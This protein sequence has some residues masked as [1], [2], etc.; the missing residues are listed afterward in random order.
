VHG[1]PVSST[2]IFPFAGATKERIPVLRHFTMDLPSVATES[3]NGA[4]RHL[5]SVQEIERS[6]RGARSISGEFLRRTKLAAV[7]AWLPAMMLLAPGA[8]YGELN[9]EQKAPPASPSGRSRFAMTWDGA[10]GQVV[11]FGGDDGSSILGDTWVWD[12]STWTQKFPA[13]SPPALRETSMAYDA[14]RGQV[15]LFGGWDGRQLRSD[16]WIWDGST[17]TQTSPATSPPARSYCGLAGDA[18]RGQVVLFGGRNGSLTS[19]GDTWVWDGGT[20]TQESPA[21]SPPVRYSLGMAYDAARS[22]VVLFGGYGGDYLADTWVWDGSTWTQESPAM[23]PAARYALELTW[24][25]PK[26]QVVLFSGSNRFGSPADTWVW[27]GS[28]WAQQSP[29]VNPPGRTKF[30]M[31]YDELRQQVVIFGGL[32]DSSTLSDTWV[33]YDVPTVPVTITSALASA[34]FSVSGSNCQAG[35]GY[36]V[37]QTFQWLPGSFC[38]VTFTS[39]VSAGAG[40]QGIFTGWADGETSNPRTI[41][42]PSSPTTYTANYKTQYQLSILVSPPGAGTVAGQGYYDANTPASVV[43]TAGSGYLFA[44]WTPVLSPNTASSSVSMTGPQTLTAGFALLTSVTVPAVSGQYSD[45]VTLSATVGPPGA[46]FSGLLQFQVDGVNAGAPISVSGSGAYSTSYLITG[47]AGSHTITVTLAP[48]TPMALGSMGSNTLT[49]TREDATITPASGNPTTVKVSSPGGTANSITLTGQLREVSDG[50]PGDLSK[51]VVTVS[52]LPAISGSPAISCTVSDAAG[53]L[54][55]TCSHVPVNAYTVEWNIT[56]DYYQTTQVNTVLAVY[57]PSLGFVTGSGSV[58]I[59]GV[60][61]QFSLSVK[62]NQDGT[63]GGGGVSFVEHLSTGDVTIRSTVLNSMEIVGTT[64]V[65][66]GQGTVNGSGAWPLRV[67]VTDNGT[68]GVNRDLFGLQA[69][70]AISFD[71][72]AITSGN[73][74]VH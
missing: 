58:M 44:G 41:T 73:I 69:S 63:I 71:P 31:A 28:T 65:I 49:V 21:M 57:D 17:W 47:K 72:V 7:A 60:P 6:G 11:L 42:V 53:S 2:L 38:T 10:R 39:P 8:A 64:A 9:W 62:Y 32:G 46:V 36:T 61:A 14:A 24:F 1:A 74:Q 19:L 40:T 50:S 68:P 13:N 52:L 33:W 12:G 70:P 48:S 66:D 37:P 59:N 15:V 35:S 5:A 23:S 30:G 20:W 25:A 55:A 16:T 26:S 51:A 56:G 3:A 43:A 4:R 34:T 54:T 29:A 22:Q 27:D 67:T 18:A 45:P